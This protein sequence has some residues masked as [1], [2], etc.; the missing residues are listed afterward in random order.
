LRSAD[1]IV[2]PFSIVPND[3][4]ANGIDDATD[5]AGGTSVDQNANGVPDECEW[6]VAVEKSV[7]LPPDGAIDACKTH[8]NGGTF[9]ATIYVQPLFVFVN[10]AELD[11]GVPASPENVKI[12]DTGVEGRPPIIFEFFD[13][14]FSI[15]PPDIGIYTTPCSEG[16]FV[17]GVDTSAPRGAPADTTCNSHITPGSAHYF[18]PPECFEH[19]CTYGAAGGPFGTC[20]DADAAPP[21]CAGPAVCPATPVTF[22]MPGELCDGPAPAPC[23]DI[24]FFDVALDDPGDCSADPD[25]LPFTACVQFYGPP[26]S[27]TDTGILTGECP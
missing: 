25:C 9:D 4:N 5:I 13:R 11:S 19:L 21:F 20:F 23:P 15:C 18:C 27:C 1:P 16:N 10:K 3:S 17:P 24:G 12:L 6:Y 2:V 7:I 8:P 14:P 22:V 26:T